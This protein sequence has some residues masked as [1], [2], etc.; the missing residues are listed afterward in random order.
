MSNQ[1]KIALFVAITIAA[2]SNLL[3]AGAATSSAPRRLPPR[4][5]PI[6]YQFR[7]GDLLTYGQ[8]LESE[9][10][11]QENPKA[12]YRVRL[13]WQ[14]KMYVLAADP[15]ATWLAVQYNLKSAN[16]SNRAVFERLA[17]KD[18]ARELLEIYDS[19]DPEF[20]RIFKL[21]GQGANES[22]SY[23][24][25]MSSS[26]IY[27]FMSRI[28]RLPAVPFEKGDSYLAREEDTL[29]VVYE[30]EQSVPRGTDYVFTAQHPSGRVLLTVSKELGVTDR[31]EY[32]AS[33]V[34]ENQTRREGYSFVLRDMRSAPW[35]GPLS[36]PLVNKALVAGAIVRPE[37]SCGPDVVKAFL[38]SSDPGRQSVGAAY[39][40]LR[41][42]PDGLD[43]QP[44]LK[45]RNP[46]VRFN[47]AKSVLKYRGDSGPMRALTLDPDVYVRRRAVN[48][49]ERSSYM[50][51]ASIHA[52]YGAVERWLYEGGS[53][54]AVRVDQDD[55]IRHVLQF[56]KPANALM[57]GFSKN[58]LENPRDP[59][60]PYYLYLPDDYDPAEVYPVFVYLGMGD[61]R[62]DYALSALVNGLK[63]AGRLSQ[64]ILLVPQA[65]G[66]WWEPSAEGPLNRILLTMLHSV[67]VD[68]NQIYLG[69]SSNG[70]MGTMFYGTHLP[71]RFAA[72][73][74]NMG[75][76]VL[77]RDFLT[78]PLNLDLLKNLF[79]AKVF[80]SH[81]LDDAH[82]TPDGDRSAYAQLK[83]APVPATLLELP[84][85]GHDI[86]IA[87]VLGRALA[88][89]ETSQRDP[90]PKRIDFIM[91]EPAYAA[92]YWIEV[93][94][95]S[96]LPARVTAHI[97]GN[98]VDVESAGVRQMR[99]ALDENLVD[100]SKP[101]IVR[102]NGREL[103]NGQLHASAQSLLWSA[104]ERMDAQMGY[105]VT[106]ALE[107]AT[108]GS[109]DL[110]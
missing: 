65:H 100:L 32:T 107:V 21:D 40:G 59:E 82:V 61:G 87:D 9:N 49:F 42:I 10:S 77:E 27:S 60:H 84:G 97:T 19:L 13:E 92:C 24:L 93:E 36:N 86:P 69:G 71:D 17:G 50:I 39:C 73:A 15:G 68:T 78:K 57:P 58:F 28:R 5:T 22:A 2:G 95:Y 35:P 53:I 90:F 103:F 64:Y 8:V 51:P 41:G 54:P 74:S 101:V 109:H 98:T 23:N 63:K 70:G 34:A 1:A 45:S 102:V 4:I 52:L 48:F 3:H 88:V 72:L 67:S 26:S 99:L 25:T 105:S 14:V 75:Y 7:T 80:L 18:E 110:N 79:N 20:T 12:S 11:L 76:P 31:L 96:V 62:G 83:K 106:I 81:G 44:Y 43:P 94:D 85:K 89:F 104:K 30:G 37:L 66:L 33:Y 108:D 6:Q 38:D 56:I 16:V 47:A 46:L 29:N 91:N 55:D